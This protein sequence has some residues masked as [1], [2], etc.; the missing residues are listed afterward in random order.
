MFDTSM[1]SLFRQDYNAAETIIENIKEIS[2]FRK[3]GCC[4]I[5]DWTLKMAPVCV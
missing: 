1:E 2:D 3:R 4:I 5:S